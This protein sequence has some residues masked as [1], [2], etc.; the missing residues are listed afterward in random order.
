MNRERDVDLD[1]RLDVDKNSNSTTRHLLAASHDFPDEDHWE[2]M[3][4]GKKDVTHRIL[5][6]RRFIALQEHRTARKSHCKNI[7]LQEHRISHC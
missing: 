4:C 1:T 7:A 6:T 3:R 5:P 2:I